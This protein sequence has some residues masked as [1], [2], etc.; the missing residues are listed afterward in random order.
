MLCKYE[1][2]FR[3]LALYKQYVR[4]RDKSVFSD[5]FTMGIL[6]DGLAW[7]E[8]IFDKYVCAN[9]TLLCLQPLTINLHAHAN[10]IH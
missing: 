6:Q 5:L 2:R 3:H 4:L 8:V 7:M 1:N 10:K 9:T